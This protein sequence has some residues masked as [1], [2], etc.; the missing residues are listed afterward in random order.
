[1]ASAPPDK[2]ALLAALRHSLQEE[3]DATRRRA[4]DAAELESAL[5]R[6]VGM[7]VR[8]L[9]TEDAVEVSALVDLRAGNKS[10]TYFLVV[11]GGGEKL[12]LGNKDVLTLATN[13]PLGEA[14]MGLHEGEEAELRTPQGSR[15][16]EVVRI[17]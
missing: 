7:P 17:Q 9:T 11:A 8:P 4:L 5:A 14:L 15:V 12:R 13:S 6:L 1:M 10:T 3:L 16:M 2:Q